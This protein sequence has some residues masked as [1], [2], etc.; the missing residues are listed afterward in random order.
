MIQMF[1]E[2][3]F[4]QECRIWLRMALKPLAVFGLVCLL[5][6][7]GG[8]VDAHLA[9]AATDTLACPVG[10]EADG[11]L[12]YPPCQLD[13][14]GIGPVCYKNCPS[15]YQS[16]SRLCFKEAS[17]F[18]KA[19]YTRG[20]GVG[21][22]C[23][24]N[25]ESQNGLC[26]PR[27]NAG[28][29][30]VGPVC[31]QACRAGYADHGVTCF[32]HIFDFYG[33]PTYGRGAGG[34]VS[35]CAPGLQ[36]NGALCYPPC[37]NGFAGA[38]PVCFQQCP[39]QYRD[40]GTTCR[41]DAIVFATPSYGRGAGTVMNSLPVAIDETART[42]KDTPVKLVF[43]V[44]N[45]DNDELSNVIFV[46]KPSHGE[47]DA[48]IYT[49]NPG[50]EGSDTIVWKTNDGKHD[51]NVAIATVLVGNVD[52]NVAPVALDRTVSVTEDTPISITVT[53]TDGDN[54]E[55]FYQLL[56][57]PQHGEYQWLPPNTVIYTPTVDF[58]GTD[59][60]TF[61]SHDGQDASN[62]SI[63]TLTVAAMNDA[64][65]ALAQPISTTRNSNV[66]INLFASDAENDPI[67]YTVVSSPT[68]GL[69]SG[70]VPNLLYTPQQNFVGQDS[71]Q[72]Q[73]RDPQGAATVATISLTVLPTNTAP[74]ADSL[75][76]TTSEESAVAVNLTASDAD[77]DALIYTLVTSPTHGLLLGDHVDW[78]YT[79]NAGFTGTDTFT[80]KANDGQ[81]DSA[82][83]TVTINVVAVPAEASVVGIIYEDSNG[84][85]QPDASD[86]GVSGLLVTL[87]SANIQAA[88]TAT[89]FTTQTDAIGAWRLD[90]VP[91]GE[92]TLRISSSVAVQVEAP[93]QTAL[94][95]GQ[96]GVQQLSPAGVKI[97]G[98]SLFLPLIQR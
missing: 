19:S 76:L 28:Y 34:A 4:S 70:G 78:V 91:L 52:P 40:D 48:G 54:D 63:I 46:Q 5:F 68:H 35:V 38:G 57:K 56:D 17:I 43:K 80:F 9:H 60:F 23:A 71:L 8:Q 33:K 15:G 1:I 39:A 50:F 47:V 6:W 79:P 7:I 32:K 67:T 98:R 95:V 62:T 22:S 45:F 65:A 42:P 88:G 26:Y 53:C 72:F 77:N 16:D 3:L 11:G 55:L 61:R 89:S 51:S 29:Y 96:R 83:A 12:C 94:L 20:A 58:V 74:L 92:Y 73:A 84:N 97:T 75:I 90:D 82:L 44:D 36:R 2:F 64:P 31:W 49:P 21:L 30:G 13:Y 93:I 41:K 25:Q 24:T 59:S 69:L 85:G 27:C 87:T 81:A 66:V 86:S 14:Y 37:A 10:Q 18:A